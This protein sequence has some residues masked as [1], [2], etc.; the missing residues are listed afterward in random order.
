MGVD[1]ISPRDATRACVCG[2]I[3]VVIT[4]GNSFNAHACIFGGRGSH[5]IP[6]QHLQGPV[7]SASLSTLCMFLL[8]HP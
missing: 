1:E 8:E 3:Q 4:H 2:Y 7:S 5:A 6:K